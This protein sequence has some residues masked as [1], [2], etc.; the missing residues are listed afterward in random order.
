MCVCAW[1]LTMVE[2]CVS[3]TKPERMNCHTCKK[4][5][6]SFSLYP[7]HYLLGSLNFCS[8]FLPLFSFLFFSFLLSM[9]YVYDSTALNLSHSFSFIRFYLMNGAYLFTLKYCTMP[10]IEPLVLPYHW[11]F[12]RRLCSYTYTHA[13]PYM[14]IYGK[15]HFYHIVCVCVCAPFSDTLHF[16]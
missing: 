6:L 14:R 8:L 3:A 5:Q 7:P 9:A 11:I 13:Y 10:V 15:K 4:K 2:L 16:M 12:D 1:N